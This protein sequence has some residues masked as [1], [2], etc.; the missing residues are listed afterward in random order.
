MK[1]PREQSLNLG[2]LQIPVI[3]SKSNLVLPG[4]HKL[5]ILCEG[6]VPWGPTVFLKSS[7]WIWCWQVPPFQ[8]TTDCEARKISSTMRKFRLWK[9]WC[10]YNDYFI[11]NIINFGW[12][13]ID[14]KINFPKTNCQNWATKDFLVTNFCWLG[15]KFGTWGKI[16]LHWGYF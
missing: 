16:Q 12:V 5:Y 6:W 2:R 9:W 3:F 1:L 15:V 8:S 4:K 7:V 10:C 14:Y 13:T 11:I